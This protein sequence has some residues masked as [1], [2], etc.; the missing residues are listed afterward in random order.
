VI[1]LTRAIPERISSGLRRRAMQI[2]VYF[3]LLVGL[4]DLVSVI[5]KWGIRPIDRL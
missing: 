1:P 3:T 5:D 4:T 2:D